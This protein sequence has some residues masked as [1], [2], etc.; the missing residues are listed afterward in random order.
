VETS[1]NV[2]AVQVYPNPA[3]T[4]LT[5]NTGVKLNEARIKIYD[6]PGNLVWNSNFNESVFTINTFPF[7][8]GLYL[9]KIE[10]KTGTLIHAGK[11]SVRH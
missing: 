7:A 10:D 5:I 4:K 11:F 9:F 2:P 1:Q 8:N 3:N 6:L